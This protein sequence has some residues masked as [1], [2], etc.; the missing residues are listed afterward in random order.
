MQ[1]S[2][3]VAAFKDVDWASDVHFLD[4]EIQIGASPFVSIGNQQFQSVPYAL[5]TPEKQFAVYEEKYA[6]SA[7]GPSVYGLGGVNSIP[8][9]IWTGTSSSTYIQLTD[10]TPS[11]SASISN[12]GGII[13]LLP[14]TYLVRSSTTN[15]VDLA[16]NGSLAIKSRI[17]NAANVML[18]EGSVGYWY[19]GPGAAGDA[20]CSITSTM[21]Q[22]F[23][24]TG[25]STTIKF[26]RYVAR[27][28]TG[29]YISAGIDGFKIPNE[30]VILSKLYIEKIK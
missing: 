29:T 11:N 25:T 4:V 12:S 1:G 17:I 23:I 13:T 9:N 5:A 22:V 14:G 24:V 18:A 19:Y 7:G 2:S 20:G 15:E 8:V 21:E 30:A 10:Q 3:T 16:P 28:G 6:W 27:G 26:Q